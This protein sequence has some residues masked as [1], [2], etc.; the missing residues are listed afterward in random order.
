MVLR[1]TNPAAPFSTAR[2]YFSVRWTC[3]SAPPGT[4]AATITMRSVTSVSAKSSGTPYERSTMSPVPAVLGL[5]GR[6]RQGAVSPVAPW[7]IALDPR[8]HP[9]ISYS[10]RRTSRAPASASASAVV[11]AARNSA[12]DP[13]SRPPMSVSASR[14]VHPVSLV[15]SA[16]TSTRY[17]SI[18]TSLTMIRP[19]G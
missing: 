16:V 11:S 6:A 17:P 8:S 19:L 5:R 13:G 4:P 1:K 14:C 12:S 10:S 2:P 15:N 7:T 9:V 3:R 18:Q